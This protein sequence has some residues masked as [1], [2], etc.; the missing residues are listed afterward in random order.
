MAQHW[1]TLVTLLAVALILLTG[2]A[3]RAM[4][5]GNT[6]EGVW[7]I[8]EISVTSPDTN[9]TTSDPQPGLYIFCES[10]Y[11]TVLIPENK[12]RATFSDQATDEER[13]A[14]FDNFISNAGTYEMT[15][16]TLTVRPMVAKVPGAMTGSGFSYEYSLEGNLLVLVLSAAWAPTD[17]KITYR[18][19]R[20]E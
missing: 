20:L 7:K 4:T 11:S 10:H 19:S 12:S 15:G 9:W 5:Q 6:L 14:A 16:S 3:Q 2:S 13:L 17:G 1:K 18:L 8:T